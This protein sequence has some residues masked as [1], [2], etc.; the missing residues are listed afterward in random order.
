MERRYSGHH[1]FVGQFRQIGH[2]AIGDEAVNVIVSGSIYGNH[3]H[4]GP[5]RLFR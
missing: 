3:N 5:G 1:T 4:V 2:C